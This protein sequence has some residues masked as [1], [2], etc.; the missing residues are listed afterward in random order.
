MPDLIDLRA[1]PVHSTI[2]L[3]LK[4]K[5][6]KQNIF[7]A[8]SSYA[9]N[10]EGYEA[11]SQITKELLFAEDY[12]NVIQPRI[13]KASEDQQS[14][15]RNKGEV[16]TPAWLCCQM[17]NHLDE[18]W[19]GRPD[20]FSI[21]NGRNWIPNEDYIV[22]P[23]EKTWKEYVDSRRLEIAC[24]EAP[25]IVSRY[26]TANGE[27]ILPLKRRIGLLDRKL[28]IVNENA[29]SEEEWLKWAIRAVQ[30]IYGYEYQG[31]NLLVAR[32]NVLLSFTDYLEERFNRHAT[33]KELNIVANI[34]AWNLWQMDGLSGMVPYIMVDRDSPQLSFFETNDTQKLNLFGDEEEPQNETPAR[35]YDWRKDRSLEY[36]SLRREQI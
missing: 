3:L 21:M 8:T 5:T 14:R 6:T 1:Y 26:D 33:D 36:N 11:G 25:F 31:D 23:K 9:E 16:F 10:G 7:W 22:F 28:R 17:N 2:D 15:T 4:D 35:I 29:K 24:G 30:S 12:S 18:E 13:L 34:I 32:I 19:F 20:V 27:L